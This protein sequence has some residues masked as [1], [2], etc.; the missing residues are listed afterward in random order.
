MIIDEEFEELKIMTNDDIEQ[1]KFKIRKGENLAN[2]I[3]NDSTCREGFEAARKLIEY[4]ENELSRYM[5]IAAVYE[6]FYIISSKIKAE[7]NKK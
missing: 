2:A 4:Y 1:L 3:K 7:P 5:R 6:D